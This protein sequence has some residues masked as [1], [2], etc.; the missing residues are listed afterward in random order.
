MSFQIIPRPKDFSH[1]VWGRRSTSEYMWSRKACEFGPVHHFASVAQAW[2]HRLRTGLYIDRPHCARD[3]NKSVLNGPK[4]S[5]SEVMLLLF[6]LG[7]TCVWILKYY[8][9]ASFE[10]LKLTKPTEDVVWLWAKRET[11][12]L[13]FNVDLVQILVEKGRFLSSRS[14]YREEREV[15][16][17]K[18]YND[19][20]RAN[21][22]VW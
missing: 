3:W 19:C 12:M 6:V 18:C 15:W 20:W 16:L 17:M 11:N 4:W 14:E 13:I 9:L 10:S 8:R 5:V 1:K 22:G 2:Y 21:S 7:Q